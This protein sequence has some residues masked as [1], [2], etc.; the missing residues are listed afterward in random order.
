MS[1]IITTTSEKVRGA[2]KRYPEVG[3]VLRSLFPEVFRS[4]PIDVRM[5]PLMSGVSI[6]GFGVAARTS[7]Q[8]NSKGV[9]L[10]PQFE[11]KL[12]R[13]IDGAHILLAYMPGTMPTD[14]VTP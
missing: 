7:G 5:S 2:V 1:D 12:V 4:D 8:Y 9:Y 13:D 10:P 6:G 3:A 14:E 11:Y